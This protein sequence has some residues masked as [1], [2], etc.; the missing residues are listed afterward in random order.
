MKRRFFAAFLSLCLTLTLVPATAWATEP[1]DIEDPPEMS[2][3]EP[4]A[5]PKSEPE[6][7]AEEAELAPVSTKGASESYLIG[8]VNQDGTINQ[9]DLKRIIDYISGSFQPEDDTLFQLAAD[10]NCDGYI[11]EQDVNALSSVIVGSTESKGEYGSCGESVHWRLEDSG[12][13]TISGTGDMADYSYTNKGA[14]T[15]WYPSRENLKSV[16]I[17][18]GV[19]SI[20]EMAFINCNSLESIHIPDSVISIGRYA[21]FDCSSLP[22]VSIP[23]SVTSIE[24]EVFDGCS[25]LESVS[26]PSSVTSIGYRAFF[27]C[28]NL[29]NTA[30][31]PSLTSISREA[32]YGCNKMTN[33]IIPASVIE[34]SYYAFHS[35]R[36]KNYTVDKNN[37]NYCS[38]EQGI[39]FNKNKTELISCPATLTNVTIPSSV[40]GIDG[41]AFSRCSNLTNITIP[42]GVTYIG[43]WA[44][45]GCNR[46]ISMSIP[47]NITYLGRDAFCDCSNLKR[48]SIPKSV[49]EIEFQVFYGC[50]SLKDVYYSGTEAQWEKINIQDSNEPL[51]IATIHYNS[52]MPTR[53]FVIS[54]NTATTCLKKGSTFKIHVASYQ[55]YESDVIDTTV[56]EFI[57]TSSDDK[58]MEATVG[59][60]D[61]KSGREYTVRAKQAGT[62]VL[63]FTNPKDGNVRG[64][65]FT[66][67]DG[68]TGYTFERVPEMTVEPGKTTNFYNYNGMVVDDFL[69]K[70]HTNGNGNVDYYNVSMTIYNTLNLY[71]AV[72]SY[73]ANGNL[74]EVAVINKK[75]D[76]QISFVD[77]FIEL[78]HSIGDLFYLIGNKKYYSG[79]SISQETSVSLKVPVGGYLQISNSMDSEMA[80]LANVI[81]I[82]VEGTL[83]VTKLVNSADKLSEGNKEIIDAILNENRKSLAIV[84]NDNFV[85]KEIN[86]VMKKETQ[87][88]FKKGNWD[89][90]NF[91]TVLSSFIENTNKVGLDII[92]KIGEKICTLYGLASLSESAIKSS[93]PT[94]N[95]INFL[96]STLGV[97]DEALFWFNFMQSANFPNG[98]YIYAPDASDSYVSNGVKVTP[99][100]QK[101]FDMIVHVYQVVNAVDASGSKY[102]TYNITMHKDG[103]K[104][105]PDSEVQVQIP[106]SNSYNKNTVKVYRIND[107]GT[108]TDMHAS[109]INGYA[110]FTTDHFSYYALV[111]GNTDG[112]FLSH[113]NSS[114]NQTS[115]TLNDPGN[116]LD[117]AESFFAASYDDNGKMTEI[118]SGTKN[119]SNSGETQIFFLKALGQNWELYILDANGI[120][121]CR[122]ITLPEPQIT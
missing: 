20:G 116:L 6:L 104:T 54:A 4:V 121:I 12:T 120:P 38:D 100:S 62:C 91:G 57:C 9:I 53:E 36:L 106:L 46:L 39:L 13:L 66:I 31:P 33:V 117:K 34:I 67:V 3:T 80:V 49:T 18:D 86:N 108:V 84:L 89:L 37:K 101:D 73:D 75:N 42:D 113:W 51:D 27:Q 43:E 72:T 17:K 16:V 88:V 119:S 94:G 114:G 19:T 30:L 69:S 1:D 90:D 50:N 61:E 98:I 115:I 83:S 95:L 7:S 99:E 21:F 23:N 92:D 96:Y 45:H 68:E 41:R 2:T 70:P 78:G 22:S 24:D 107:D 58:I 81:G 25:S 11:N 56:K 47:E 65:D 85:G 79:Q 76:F 111:D 32:F 77:D 109:V 82:L 5:E 103:K 60:W 15:P 97:A 87:K 110:V 10:I 28:N 48:V 105:Q 40:T 102:E 26:I 122:N 118:A 14:N 52:A 64:V 112:V 63:T 59:T 55:D 8:D 29:K 74:H 93:I 71:G 35:E 44:F